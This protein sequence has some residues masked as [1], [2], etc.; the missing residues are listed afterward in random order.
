MRTWRSFR[1]GLRGLLLWAKYAWTWRPWDW[2]FAYEAYFLSVQALRA[3]VA[4]HQLHTRW[5][6][7]AAEMDEA[8]RLWRAFNDGHG[9]EEEDASW[10]ALH[11]HMK[12]HARAWWC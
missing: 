8:L 10:R 5:A 11:D 9:W 4:E 6:Q 7:D 3:H 1:Y 2:W 12:E